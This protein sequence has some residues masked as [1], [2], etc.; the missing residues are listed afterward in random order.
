MA[1]D[2]SAYLCDIIDAC[3][4]ISS[5]LVG[6]S[7]ETYVATREKRS[8]VEREFII[9]GQA[10]SM[11]A[12]FWPDLF[13]RLSD[14]RKAI[15]FRNI[16][17]HNY[18]SVDYETVYETALRDVPKLRSECFELLRESEGVLKDCPEK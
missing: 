16:L 9:I 2:I 4:S 13:K 3:N 12:K 7:M 5:I 14:G 8:A 6:I 1:R 18:A 10:A 15:G 17:T 11:L